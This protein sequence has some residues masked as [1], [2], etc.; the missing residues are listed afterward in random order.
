MKKGKL[1]RYIKRNYKKIRLAKNRA[2]RPLEKKLILKQKAIKQSVKD[3][4][5]K[6]IGGNNG[7]V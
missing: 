5:K 2:I 4:I 7:K 3:N 6:L 1:S